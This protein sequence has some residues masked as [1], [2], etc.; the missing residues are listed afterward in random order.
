[1]VTK[2]KSK[3]KKINYNLSVSHLASQPSSPWSYR[4]YPVLFLCVEQYIIRGF[5]G[6]SVI[7]GIG[8]ISSRENTKSWEAAAT[9]ILTVTLLS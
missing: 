1:M 8:N 9:Y 5:V 7:H 4:K 3:C 2:D 6:H